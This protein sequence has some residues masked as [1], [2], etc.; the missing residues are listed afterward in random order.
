[1][2]D[3]SSDTPHKSSSIFYIIR[4]EDHLSST[5]EDW[6]DPLTITLESDGTTTLHGPLPDQSA[7]VGLIK[8]LNG[9]NLKILMIERLKSI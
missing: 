9:M 4:I 1:M 7:M 2:N 8:K 5:W 3:S 6:L